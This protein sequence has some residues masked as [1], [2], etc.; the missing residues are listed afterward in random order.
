MRR[1]HLLRRLHA[2][3]AD[4]SSAEEERPR[5]SDRVTVRVGKPGEAKK[6]ARPPRQYDVWRFA[7]PQTLLTGST[8]QLT[9]HW[10][11][12]RIVFLS[13]G[14]RRKTSN[15]AQPSEPRILL[16][17]ISRR[18]LRWLLDHLHRVDDLAGIFCRFHGWCVERS[19]E[20][21]SEI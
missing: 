11:L 19:E 16:F 15:A 14:Y 12:G 3:Q 18:P 8:L 4:W 17:G 20:H 1:V 5:R 13:R 6:C 9:S 10:A 7:P 21:T 2:Q